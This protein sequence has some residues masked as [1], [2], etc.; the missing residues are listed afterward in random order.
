MPKLTI[1]ESELEKYIMD[2]A[3]QQ[4]RG[5]IERVYV[6]GMHMIFSPNMHDQMV[7]EFNQQISGGGDV[8]GHLGS[9]I[10]HIMIALY[11]QSKGQIPQAAIIPAAIMLLAKICEFLDKTKDVAVDDKVFADASHI[12]TVALMSKFDKKYANG[13]GAKEEDS[14]PTSQPAPPQQPQ[15]ALGGMQ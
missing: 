1:K 15:G 12:A 8:A 4:L 14:T 2:K 9:D 3:P 10:T 7:K 5:P 11:N 13:I 6:A